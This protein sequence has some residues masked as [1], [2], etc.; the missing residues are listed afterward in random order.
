MQ[1]SSL[2]FF[3]FVC[4]QVRFG[5]KV[6]LVCFTSLYTFVPDTHSRVKINVTNVG[7]VFFDFSNL[8]CMPVEE[9]LLVVAQNQNQDQSQLEQEQQQQ[10]QEKQQQEK[11]QQ[12]KQ[13]I[14][15]LIE[16]ASPCSNPGGFRIV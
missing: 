5:N 16:P 3:G 11:Q 4:V 9:V 7:H 15:L 13:Q 2:K 14:P 1:F 8:I 12:E 10:Q 6:M